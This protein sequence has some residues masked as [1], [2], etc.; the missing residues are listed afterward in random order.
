M[1]VLRK[2]RSNDKFDLFW[3]LTK[4]KM[5][6]LGIDEPVLPRKRR[7]PQRYDENRT[8]FHHGSV[9]EMYHQ[10]YLE[11]YDFVIN[12]ITERFDQPDYQMYAAISFCMQLKEMT[13]K[14]R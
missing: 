1:E 2:D 10:M 7:M 3:E 14:A 12:A 13:S 5:E 6:K 8:D 9:K 4:Q 11:S